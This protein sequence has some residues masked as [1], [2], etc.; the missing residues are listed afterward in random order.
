MFCKE[1]KIFFKNETR[2]DKNV[3][4]QKGGKTVFEEGGKD[5]D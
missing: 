5:R 1:A 3:R 4:E 2:G